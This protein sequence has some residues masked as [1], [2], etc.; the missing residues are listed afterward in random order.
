M[1]NLSMAL[2][3]FETLAA[4]F[5]G[6]S[7]VAGGAG[8]T[9]IIVNSVMHIQSG[10]LKRLSINNRTKGEHD[11]DDEG[12]EDEDD[13][14]V[15][16][17]EEEDKGPWPKKLGRVR[18]RAYIKKESNQYKEHEEGEESLND[19]FD[20]TKAH[21][22]KCFAR[23]PKVKSIQL[24][25]AVA[26]GKFGAKANIIECELKR[27][28][29]KLTKKQN[30]EIDCAVLQFVNDLEAFAL[31]ND[32]V[33]SEEVAKAFEERAKAHNEAV[34][35]LNKNKRKAQKTPEELA[36]NGTTFLDETS[37]N[38]NNFKSEGS[39][40]GATPTDEENTK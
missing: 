29:S 1:I 31:N 17:V 32:G 23:K 24:T 11:I 36:G 20:N 9:A 7:A 27:G 3:A 25:L 12:E 8:L 19:M 34:K 16:V 13:E 15:E 18:V 26:E 4:I 22:T 6:V 5:L 28:G 38:N 33:F 21:I 2:I 14:V 35:Q 30:E 39:S 40:N 37:N 10:T